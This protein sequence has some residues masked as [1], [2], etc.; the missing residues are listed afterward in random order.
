MNLLPT[1][2]PHSIDPCSPGSLRL[3]PP[4][5]HS[6]QPKESEKGFAGG[7]VKASGF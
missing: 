3:L 1:F 4:L 5:R 6:R 2:H 7:T